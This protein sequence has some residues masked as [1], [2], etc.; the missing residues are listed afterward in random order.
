MVKFIS[1]SPWQPQ[2]QAVFAGALRY[3]KYRWF[4]RRM[5]QFIM[6]LTGGVT[7]T[8]QDIEYTDWAKVAQFGREILAQK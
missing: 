2:L 1:N 5:I 8:S 4:D 7:D 3:S 6:K